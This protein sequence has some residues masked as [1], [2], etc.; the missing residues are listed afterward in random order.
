MASATSSSFSGKESKEAAN[1]SKL[2]SSLKKLYG[3]DFS[4]EQMSYITHHANF[5]HDFDALRENFN[6]QFNTNRTLDSI[7]DFLRH[8]GNEDFFNISQDADRY[9][10]WY[11][12]HPI[13]PGHP[14]ILLGSRAMRTELRAFLAYHHHRG[15]DFSD[16]KKSFNLTFP[17]EARNSRQLTA[18]LNHLKKDNH[19]F[20]SLTNFA[21][22][23]SWYP[24]Y[25]ETITPAKNA[26]NPA[27]SR[28]TAKTRLR[29][30]KQKPETLKNSAAAKAA[31][32]QVL[33]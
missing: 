15:M 8:C 25:E 9:Q 10:K 13:K 14:P 20:K 32:M 12:E 28:G 3:K 29:Q 18:Q 6:S 11:T 2:S 17:T 23:Y 1:R 16:L 7:D 27:A 19:L 21:A 24:K 22:R 5:C 30:G 33:R 26:R 31:Q 4:W